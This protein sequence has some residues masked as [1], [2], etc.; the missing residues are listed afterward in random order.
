MEPINKRTVKDLSLE[1]SVLLLNYVTKTKKKTKI[2]NT[3][4]L[5]R[6]GTAIGANIRE[7]QGA[8]SRNDFIHKMKIA[9]KEAEE[10]AYWL[11]LHFAI[12][13]NADL[14]EMVQKITQIRK[15]LTKIISTSIKNSQKL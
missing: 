1:F 14:S 7:A 12:N 10:T 3:N 2:L 4:Q 5:V 8:E 15:L 11:D 13:P 9:F 6:S